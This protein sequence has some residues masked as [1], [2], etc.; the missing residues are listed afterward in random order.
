MATK[1]KMHGGTRGDKPGLCRT[2][3][4]LHHTKGRAESQETMRCTQLSG[5]AQKLKWEAYE[6]TSYSDKTEVSIS[7][8]EKVAWILSSDSLTKRIG[9]VSPRDPKHGELIKKGG[10]E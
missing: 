9:F 1:F 3:M 8:M 4:W 10:E 5:P 6:C 7:R 2:C